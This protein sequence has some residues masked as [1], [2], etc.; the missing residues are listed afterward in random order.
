MFVVPYLPVTK[1]S[2]RSLLGL[3]RAEQQVVVHLYWQGDRLP[4][5]STLARSQVLFNTLNS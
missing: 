2:R 3:A 1:K 4:Q 5:G